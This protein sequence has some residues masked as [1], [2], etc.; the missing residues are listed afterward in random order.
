MDTFVSI[1]QDEIIGTLSTFDRMIIKGHLTGFYPK[2]A[3]KRFLGKQGVLLKDFGTYVEGATQTLK[4]H[5]RQMAEQA[6]CP[7][8]LPQVASRSA[9]GRT[10]PRHGC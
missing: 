10:R 3:F 9:Q 4:A 7:F 2:G 1:H 8:I 5:A 6:G